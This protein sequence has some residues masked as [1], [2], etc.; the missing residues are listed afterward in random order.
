MEESAKVL[1]SDIK[2]VV[3]CSPCSGLED[4]AYVG[5]LLDVCERTGKEL[6][7]KDRPPTVAEVREVFPEGDV[8]LILDDLTSYSSYPSNLS[9]LSSLH[10]HHSNI[11]VLYSV[12]NPF[13]AGGKVDLTTVNRNLTGR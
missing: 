10:A 6:A 4:S 7:V 1:R 12:Q 11:T 3:Y 13:Q 5:K 8:L 9:E 2:S